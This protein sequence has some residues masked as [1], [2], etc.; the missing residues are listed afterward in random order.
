MAEIDLKR[1]LNLW[2]SKMKVTLKIILLV[3]L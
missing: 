3:S 1:L 2:F